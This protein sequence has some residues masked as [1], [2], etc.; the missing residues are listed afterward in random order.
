MTKERACANIEVEANCDIGEL[1]WRLAGILQ[2]ADELCCTKLETLTVG[3]P[4]ED[5]SGIYHLV[6]LAKDMSG[7]LRDQ[8]EKLKLGQAHDKIGRAA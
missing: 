3:N 5:I 4:S 7:D 6:W 1:S 8:I 2:A